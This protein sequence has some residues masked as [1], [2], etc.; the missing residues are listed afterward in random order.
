ME[1]DREI[2]S[3]KKKHIIKKPQDIFFGWWLALAGGFLCLVGYAYSAY[4]FSA[5]FKPISS[6][7][8]FS[9]AK[10]SIAPSITRFEG[11]IEAPIVGY[12]A[13]RFGPRMTVFI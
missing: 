3:A 4:G 6:E 11:G 13:D 9:R 12:L 10:A 2:V 7:L 5:L 1:R 8:G